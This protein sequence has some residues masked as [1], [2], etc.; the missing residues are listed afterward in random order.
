M[1]RFV[2]VVTLCTAAVLLPMGRFGHGVLASGGNNDVQTVALQRQSCGPANTGAIAGSARFSLDDQGG[3]KV[4]PNGIEIDI[5]VTDGAARTAYNTFVLD[6][7]CQ[8]LFV[9]ESLH[10]DDRGRGDQE[11]HV[12][13]SALPSGATLRVQLVTS[14]AG[15]T[16]DTITS[17]PT[18]PI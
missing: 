14:A 5:S 4:N 16:T 18:S 17:D 2:S 3:E 10:T 11:F 6:N 13:G 1:V 8:V 12:P 15:S 9:G 7:A